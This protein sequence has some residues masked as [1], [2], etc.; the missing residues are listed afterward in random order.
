MPATDQ[1]P[2]QCTRASTHVALRRDAACPECGYQPTRTEALTAD[3][4]IRAAAL[5]A[6]TRFHTGSGGWASARA[7]VVGDAE[8]FADYIRDGVTSE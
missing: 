1:R 6:A 2:P 3:Q 5:D 4:Q 7:C 8:W